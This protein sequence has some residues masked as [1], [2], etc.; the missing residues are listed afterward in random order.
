MDNWRELFM[1]HIL[2]RESDYY[3]SSVVSRM[4]LTER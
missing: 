2:E 4:K 3:E 1:A